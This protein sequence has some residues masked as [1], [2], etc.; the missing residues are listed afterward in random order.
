VVLKSVWQAFTDLTMDIHE[1]LEKLVK[2]DTI[3]KKSEI[4]D[5]SYT[6]I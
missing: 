2:S 3:V 5:A 6:A 1:M 4:I